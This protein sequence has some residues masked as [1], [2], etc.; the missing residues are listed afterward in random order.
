M[1]IYPG[2]I[3]AIQIV[4]YGHSVNHI[5]QEKISVRE[6]MLICSAITEEKEVGCESY[7]LYLN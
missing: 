5:K 4:E 3:S 6:T 1:K 2:D 7:L